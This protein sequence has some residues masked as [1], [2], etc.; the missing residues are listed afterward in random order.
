M[1]SLPYLRAGQGPAL[2]LV[3]GYL[4][5]ADQWA[6]EIDRFS[7]DHDVIAPNLPGFGAASDLPGHDTIGAMAQSLLDLLDHL[8]VRSFTLLGHSMGGM[9]AQEMASRRRHS[10][11]KLILYGTGPIGRMPDRFEPLATS[12]SRLMEDGVPE[13]IARIGATW[14]KSGH[15]APGYA[16]VVE[17]GKKAS[18]QAAMAALDAMAV[19]DGRDALHSLDMPTLVIW[20]D[21]DRS[22]RWPQVEKLWQDISDADLCVVPSASH[23]VHLEKPELFQK[24]VSDFVDEFGL[25]ATVQGAQQV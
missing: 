6:A 19:W 7:H 11:E 1:S 22:Y 25:E 15:C 18:P 17:I 8:Q 13:T 16:N 23:A 9:I 4:G 20:G 12:R 24:L 21:S 14:F 10:V 5:G 3:H 2:V